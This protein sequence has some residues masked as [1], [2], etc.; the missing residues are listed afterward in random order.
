MLFSEA[1]MSRE[2]LHDTL[3]FQRSGTLGSSVFQQMVWAGD[4]NVNYEPADGLP[5][6]ITAGTYLQ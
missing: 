2:K 6:V 4:Q 3:T 1:L 5:S